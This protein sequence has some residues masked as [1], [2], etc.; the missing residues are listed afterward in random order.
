MKIN[1]I[2]KILKGAAVTMLVEAEEL[3]S[4]VLAET[5]RLVNEKKLSKEIIEEEVG[6]YALCYIAKNA[7]TIKEFSFNQQC[8]VGRAKS[9]NDLDISTDDKWLSKSHFKIVVDGEGIP[10]IEDLESRNGTY[11]NDIKI[12]ERKIL[13]RGDC[14]RAGHSI[15]IFL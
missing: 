6:H 8:Q 1:S 7:E 10:I 11:V 12:D 13:H 9:L 15:F 14:I 2:D 5:A 3:K 4:N